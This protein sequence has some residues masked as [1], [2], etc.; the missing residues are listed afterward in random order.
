MALQHYLW[1][2]TASANGSADPA[3]NF[4]EGQSPSSVNDSARA[5]MASS[6]GFRDDISGAIVAG[7]TATA[8]TV[9]TYQ[10]FDSLPHAHGQK[11]AFRPNFTNGAGPVTIN[12]DGLGAKPLRSTSTGELPPSGHLPAGVLVAG[13]PYTAVYDSG[14]DVWYLH[15]LYGNPYNI[16]L[17]GGLPFF[18]STAPNSSFA[19][20]YGQAVSRATY[21]ALFTLFSTTYG[22]GDG[23]TTFNLP[24]LRGRF[25]AG[26]DD[27]GGSAASRLTTAAGA[28]DGATLGAVGGVQSVTL[29]SNQIPSLTSTGSNSIS[30]SSSQNVLKAG[31]GLQQVGGGLAAISYV[32]PT[33]GALA[34][35]GSNSISVTYTNGSQV[36][37]K[38][39][40]PAL[41]CNFI[42]RII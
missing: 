39:V 11:I 14:D 5:L 6:A 37:V 26:K 12:V 31:G 35:S 24:D 8:Y 17:G 9:A 23:S 3:V 4:L 19:F 34:S 30:V 33:D 7:G 28:V 29:A 38:P 20:P 25:L 16:P 2:R 22:I 42:L 36:T 18:G 32:S 15:G 13:T 21:S 1:S 27:M 41:V 10:V 40:P